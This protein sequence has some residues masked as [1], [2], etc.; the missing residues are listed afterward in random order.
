MI[1][2]LVNSG[3]KADYALLGTTLT[4]GNQVS[5]D[6]EGRQQDTQ[7]VIDVCLDNQLETMR[8]GLGAWYVATIIIPPKQRSLVESG[9]V[10][11]E[12]NAIMV[13]TELPLDV[14]KVELHLWSLPEKPRVEQTQTGRSD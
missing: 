14:N 2:T 10:D 4:I 1:I 5:I 12:G 9:E 13:E 8:E 3:T 7:H 11:E 6:L